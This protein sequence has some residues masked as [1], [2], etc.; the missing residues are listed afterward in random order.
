[1]SKA[2]A[3]CFCSLLGG[4]LGFLAI[5]FI[6]RFQYAV[7]KYPTFLVLTAGGE[8]ELQ[9]FFGRIKPFETKSYPL[10]NLKSLAPEL[11]L[12]KISDGLE[13][14]IRRPALLEKPLSLQLILQPRDRTFIKVLKMHLRESVPAYA[15]NYL[16]ES[17]KLAH[18]I[19]C[20]NIASLIGDLDELIRTVV[21]AVTEAD[22]AGYSPNQKKLKAEFLTVWLQISVL[23]F[24]TKLSWARLYMMLLRS[25]NIYQDVDEIM[26][27]Y[28]K[29]RDIQS[30]NQKKAELLELQQN[31]QENAEP[32]EQCQQK[33]NEIKAHDVDPI[34]GAVGQ[35][36]K[37][38]L[39]WITSFHN[40]MKCFS[41]ARWHHFQSHETPR[42]N[43][44]LLENEEFDTELDTANYMRE[45]E[46]LTL[47]I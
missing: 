17:I 15:K 18:D 36:T 21:Q 4:V 39:K 9:L 16:C 45:H 40:R 5:F 31:S 35:I 14:S 2:A 30:L 6:W 22:S 33:I 41:F 47:F 34:D 11:A 28:N 37:I 24:S 12:A 29:C 10:C 8:C 27:F 3:Y 7:S 26:N 13:I 23:D 46:L 32:I 43:L 20:L 44:V 1:M 19:S 42:E 25:A 38:Q